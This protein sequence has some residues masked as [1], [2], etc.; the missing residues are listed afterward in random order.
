MDDNCSD[1]STDPS[2]IELDEEII[3]D[4]ISTYTN[5]LHFDI[6]QTINNCILCLHINP[7]YVLYY[8]LHSKCLFDN[9][10]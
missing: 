4:D 1:I 8:A 6:I 9:K 5:A 3:T 10:E 2:D 7:L